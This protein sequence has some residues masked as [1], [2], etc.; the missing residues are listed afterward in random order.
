MDAG[1]VVSLKR[2]LLLVV[3]GSIGK[4]NRGWGDVLG[5]RLWGER[6][7]VGCDRLSER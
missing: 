1:T 6:L 2:P 3:Q 4:G 7:R 5:S